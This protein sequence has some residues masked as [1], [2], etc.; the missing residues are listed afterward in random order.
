MAV[1]LTIL[2]KF[3]DR[4]VASAQRRMG[5]LGS[6][7]RGFSGS[8]GADMVRAGT[9][10]QRFSDR[11]ANVG[12][13]LTVGVSLPLVAMGGFAVH[14]SMKFESAFTGVQKTVSATTGELAALKTGIRDMA[15]Q[16]P[17]TREEIAGVAES[18][19]QLGIQTPN[20]LAF[21][22]TMID[23]GQSTNLASDEAATSF[24]RF[25]NIVKMPQTQFDRLGS[26]V[27]ALGNNMATT[28]SEIVA[29]G[30]RIAGAG[31]QVGMTEPQ[32]MAL[33]ASLSSVGIE[34]EAGGTAVSK[35]MIGI[36][37]A[38][39]KGGVALDG[40]AETAGMSA[41]E[42]SAAWERDPAQALNTV[43]TGL[44]DM[45]KRGGSTLQQL[46]KLGITEVRQRDA[47]LRAA[48]AGDLLT[49]SLQIS[50]Q[51]WQEN[52]ALAKEAAQ[53]YK[54][55]ESRLTI[56][57]N[58]AT[59]AALSAGEA[60]TP[61]L[62]DSADAA[63]G[64]ANGFRR[65]PSGMQGAIVK[66]GV[67][68]AALGPLT[69]VFAK[70]GGLTG[71]V[72][73][74]VGNIRIAFGEM[75]AFAPTWARSIA[76]IT[77]SIGALSAAARAG[78]AFG[79]VTGALSAFGSTLGAA[80][81]P[82][83]IAVG[84]IATTAALTYGVVRL[85]NALTGWDEKAALMKKS[86]ADMASNADLRSWADRKFGG[87]V[88]TES[89]SVT[90]K[91]AVKLEPGKSGLLATWIRQEAAKEHAAELEHQKQ[92]KIDGARTIQIQAEQLVARLEAARRN[93]QNK[94]A[95]D[96]SGLGK[97]LV[98]AKQRAADA[99]A[100][101]ARLT[102]Q[103]QTL[104]GKNWR[105]QLGAHDADL[106]AAIRKK[107]AELKRLEKGP[108]TVEMDLK[109]DKVRR[110]LAALKAERAR[111]RATRWEG[112]LLLRTEKAQGR[113]KEIDKA[114]D[115]AKAQA[116]KGVDVGAKI[117]RL[118]RAKRQAQREL[119]DLQ[120]Q[121][122]EPKIGVQDNA[123][124]PARNIR[125]GL[126]TIFSQPI[127]QT[128]VVRKTGSGGPGDQARGGVYESSRATSAVW[129]EAGREIAAFF[130]MN[131]PTRAALVMENLQSR[132]AG[133]M[134]ASHTSGS[135]TLPAIG[136]ATAGAATVVHKHYH[137]HLP[138]GTAL[139]GEA[140]SV[141]RILAPYISRH[142]DSAD[143]LSG[144]GR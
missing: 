23:L 5:N 19:G 131:D 67:A 114:L 122:T 105:I 81:G 45:E 56:L 132:L 7:A 94:A 66:A 80:L 27:V 62:M 78:G 134:R 2:S 20:I 44:A 53:R 22:R 50:G 99:G 37:A 82:A 64:L 140:E 29:M 9:A 115:A 30:M 26:T 87:H 4:G 96:E 55:A 139:V 61:A 51:A 126:A 116:A 84:A 112:L 89:G 48:G 142:Q 85:T 86:T 101:Y 46:E 13:R 138:G 3:D 72:I 16:I 102:G 43:I 124:T 40:W 83:G 42:F 49:Q 69:F 28:E 91:P 35:T 34:A 110:K 57:K 133:R 123:T 117:D 76:H 120:A 79:G 12:K 97:Q 31:A 77:R 118:T 15:M 98:D 10:L 113:L 88:V 137:V 17:S 54:T 95:F 130:P 129:G 33:A 135:V 107:E 47:L 68:A 14:E 59:D 65:L 1:T 119:R 11:A 106:T 71:G 39:Q 38:V 92:M 73:K 74:G 52:G 60:L 111:F 108:H 21:T 32:I 41:K 6:S 104:T 121:K 70:L 141:A 127:V 90:W 63:V 24:A 100:E 93:S 18:A 136:S 128:V 144:R 109:E 75:G 58:K 8:M 25:A 103:M 36:E 125:L 143:A